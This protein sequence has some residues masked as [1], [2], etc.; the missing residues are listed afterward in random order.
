MK[1]RNLGSTTPALTYW[2]D[3]EPVIGT[4]CLRQQSIEMGPGLG[5]GLLWYLSTHSINLE[6]WGEYYLRCCPGGAAAQSA[7]SLG[8]LDLRTAHDPH[9]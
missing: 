1:T 5:P 9:G 6:G 7:P 8:S 4:S 2:D 3:P